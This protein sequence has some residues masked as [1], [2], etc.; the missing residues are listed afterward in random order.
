MATKSEMNGQN[1][2]MPSMSPFFL[3]T[4]DAVSN[5]RHH[6][7]HPLQVIGPPGHLPH[8]IMRGMPPHMPWTWV[9]RLWLV[10]IIVNVDKTRNNPWLGMVYTCLYF[11]LYQLY[12][13]GDD[14]GVVYDIVLPTLLQLT[15]P[16]SN[17]ATPPEGSFFLVTVYLGVV[18]GMLWSCY[19]VGGDGANN[20][21][22]LCEMVVMLC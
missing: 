21:P 18:R 14:W 2:G 22:V 3:L 9:N 7:N 20:I 12:I 1:H 17:L 19:W 11:I 8:G 6:Q 5:C 10:G 4:V 13:Y 15:I 16:F